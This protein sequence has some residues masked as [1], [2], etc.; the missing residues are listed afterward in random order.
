M[1]RF[2]KNVMDENTEIK[3][4]INSII[5]RDDEDIYFVSL[6]TEK[7]RTIK[8]KQYFTM[9][10]GQPIPEDCFILTEF[11]EFNH[12][13]RTK[14]ITMVKLHNGNTRILAKQL[15]VDG[16][17]TAAYNAARKILGQV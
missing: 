3:P 10:D 6:F 12:E 8:D 1:C 17:V 9:Y 13:I 15:S 5:F 4:I 11:H 2:E 14:P 7:K 16:L